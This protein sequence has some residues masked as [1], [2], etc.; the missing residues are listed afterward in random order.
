MKNAIKALAPAIAGF[1]GGPAGLLAQAGVQFIADKLGAKEATVEAINETLK[2]LGPD[3]HIRLREIDVEFQKFAMANGIQIALAQIAVN[4]EEA[5]SASLLKSGW[6]PAAGWVCVVALALT[7]WPKAVVLTG[8]WVY[9]AVSI[10]QDSS[11][12]VTVVV[13]PFPDLGVTDLLGLLASLLG[14]AGFRTYER[15]HGVEP[16]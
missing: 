7:Y 8:I 1:L 13:P 11:S 6:R 3:H 5:K 9:Q 12:I 16:H 14:L 2:G 4:Q 10:I 15:K